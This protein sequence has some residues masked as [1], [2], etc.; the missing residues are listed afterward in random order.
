MTIFPFVM[1]FLVVGS[2]LLVSWQSG[3]LL[4]TLHMR[5]ILGVVSL[6]VPALLILLILLLLA[7][8]R[9]RTLKRLRSQRLMVT[10]YGLERSN[11]QWTDQANFSDIEEVRLIRNTK[12]EINSLLVKTPQLNLDL[13]MLEDKMD[14]TALLQERLP[15]VPLRVTER[16]WWYYGLPILLGISLAGALIL[17]PRWL[18]NVPNIN[19]IVQTVWALGFG[20]VTLMRRNTSNGLQRT[21]NHGKLQLF[22]GLAFVMLMVLFYIIF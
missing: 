12:G 5:G 2:I 21:H 22:M 4:M 20:L 10:P 14:I 13:S 15:D 1:T 7:P 11:G 3:T 8:M 9:A 16:A 6:L 18:T 19:I 17:I